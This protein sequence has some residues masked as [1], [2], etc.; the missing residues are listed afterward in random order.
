MARLIGLLAVMVLVG[1]AQAAFDG[2]GVRQLLQAR[3]Q[4]AQG[5][6]ATISQQQTAKA[7]NQAVK[8]AAN[9]RATTVAGAVGTGTARTIAAPAGLTPQTGVLVTGAPRQAVATAPAP[10]P[11]TGRHLLQARNQGAQGARATIS[12]QQTAKAINQAVKSAAN[13]RA[14]TVAGAVGTGTARTIAAPAGLTP[15][16]GVLVTGAPRQAVA[17]APAPRPTTGRHLLQ[18]RNQG[19]QGARATISQQQ[20]AKAINQAVKSAANP[21]A[22]T[23]AG[24]VGTGTAR[25]IAAPAG[26]TPQTGVLVTGAPRQAVATAPAPRPTTGR[27]LLQARNQGSQGARA[28]ISQQ[29]TA[30]AIN[31]AVASAADPRATAKA[32]TVGSGTARL[33]AAPAG[34]SH[35]TGVLVAGAPRQAVATAPAPAPVKTDNHA[36]HQQG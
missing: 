16:T 4:G 5:A 20:T 10:R 11:T 21:R 18:A 6:R 26:L 2:A 24:A 35:G 22:T 13:P 23:V 17:T 25:T 33:I 7:I 28:T 15:Q 31:Q 27:H 9:P 30:K 34:V 12:Q 32:G 19:A 14:T 36:T 3:N 1:S 29:Q 8:S